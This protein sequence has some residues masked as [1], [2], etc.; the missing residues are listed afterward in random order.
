MKS[1]RIEDPVT[2]RKFDSRKLL[3][4]K[5]LKLLRVLLI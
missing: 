5:E 3:P 1:Y 2:K 4:D